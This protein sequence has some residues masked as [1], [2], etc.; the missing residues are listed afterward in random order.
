MNV[1]MMDVAITQSGQ[2]GGTGFSYTLLVQG[3]GYDGVQSP[4]FPLDYVMVR[5]CS[6]EAQYEH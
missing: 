4:L 5:D 1:D 2:R 3:F 6:T